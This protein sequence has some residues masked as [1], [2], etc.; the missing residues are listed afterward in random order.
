MVIYNNI[1]NNNFM[2]NKLENKEDIS[3]DEGLC[4]KKT[5]IKG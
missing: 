4:K 5:L 2:I 3:K 1:N